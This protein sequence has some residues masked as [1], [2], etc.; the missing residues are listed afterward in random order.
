MSSLTRP[1]H[2]R[3]MLLV[4]LLQ[5]RQFGKLI[6]TLCILVYSLLSSHYCNEAHIEC[7]KT[8]KFTTVMHSTFFR[9]RKLMTYH[10]TL[11][12]RTYKLN[13]ESL[14]YLSRVNTKYSPAWANSHG[15]GR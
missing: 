9:Y 10:R 14:N 3:Q 4:L 12:K 2:P 8:P 13:G 11:H 7:K 1:V 5:Q 6:V 15:D